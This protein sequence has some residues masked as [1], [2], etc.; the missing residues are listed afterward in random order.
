DPSPEG[1][2]LRR[3]MLSAAR[4]A[5]QTI[6]HFLSVV[7]CPLS[8]ETE[9]SGASLENV[10]GDAFA[11]DWA[12]ANPLAKRKAAV[13]DPFAERKASIDD[14]MI[15]EAAEVGTAVVQREA[16]IRAAQASTQDLRTEA[17]APPAMPQP[18]ASFNPEPLRDGGP[19]PLR[20]EANA[21]Q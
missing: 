6:K 7:G 14:A 15:G 3:Y 21:P 13:G 16:T 20:T 8:V 19:A 1:E 4:V 5:N 9:D 2:K 12:Y 18:E 11:L 10:E 17:N